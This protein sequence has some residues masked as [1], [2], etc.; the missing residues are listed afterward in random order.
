[1]IQILAVGPN[2]EFG[3]KGGLP[4][5][6]NV[7]DIKHFK[8]TTSRVYNSIIVMGKKT[9]ESLPNKY[10]LKRICMVI[11]S[12]TSLKSFP[13]VVF[14]N[15][16]QMI[17]SYKTEKYG[18]VP[19]FIIGG[20]TLLQQ[21]LPWTTK[22]IISRIQNKNLTADVFINLEKYPPIDSFRLVKKKKLNVN[23]VVETFIKIL[24][25]NI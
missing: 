25:I 8:R 19:W 3:Y 14:V 15:F 24:K 10:L 17:E 21:T 1:M 7:D 16:D 5:Q 4:W 2:G 11:T 13:G 20:I 6:K 18:N 12:D 23:T 9:Y 22:I